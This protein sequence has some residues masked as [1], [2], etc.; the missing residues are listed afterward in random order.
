VLEPAACLAGHDRIS[1]CK[2]VV[3]PRQ[4]YLPPLIYPE[5]F[6]DDIGLSF[7][8]IRVDACTIPFAG[9]EIKSQRHAEVGRAMTLTFVA[10]CPLSSSFREIQLGKLVVEVG[11]SFS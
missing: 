2:V 5:A 11:T 6:P 8:E 10:F 7:A 3:P 9:L 4:A 1:Y